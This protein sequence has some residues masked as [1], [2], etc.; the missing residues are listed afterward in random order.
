[1]SRLYGC[2]ISPD[3]VK[4]NRA[5]LVAVADKF[6]HSIE[7]IEDGVLFDL[8]GLERLIGKP[9]KI[10]QKINTELRLA[11]ISGSIAVAENI[12]A[13]TLLARAKHGDGQTMI[14]YVK[15]L[16]FP[17]LPLDELFLEPDTLNVFKDLGLHTIEDLLAVP[18]SDLIDRYGREF[19][20]VIRTIR[21]KGDRLLS[22][23]VK[24]SQVSWSF[25]LDNAVEDFEQLIFLLNHGLEML[26]AG[27]SRYGH[28]TE[29]LDITFQLCRSPRMS[30]GLSSNTK[31][32]EIKSSTPSLDRAFW[33]KLVNVRV[34]LD[35]PEAGIVG[36]DVTAHFTKQ[37]PNQR[38]LYAVSRPEPESLLLTV[39]KIKKLVGKENVGIPRLV[40]QRLAHPFTLD[41]DAIPDVTSDQRLSRLAVRRGSASPDDGPFSLA[42]MPPIRG[43]ASEDVESIWTARRASPQC[44]AAEPQRSI[45][46]FTWFNP[47]IPAEVLMRSG[48]LVFI[49]TREFSGHIVNCSGV[50]RSNS[51]WWD[52]PWKVQEW[53]VEVENGGIY[54]V[55]KREKEWFVT[56]EYD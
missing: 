39:G 14:C 41:A 50:W 34:S 56:G 36:V 26:F 6:S 5:G 28:S 15:G 23:N 9:E 27:V 33:L 10:S 13:A 24:E 35:P 19:E 43:I 21:Q 8:T 46:A 4:Q 45:L 30:K 1:M 42:A 48:E 12:E 25:A 51:K 29:Q 52:K 55:C 47:P 37:R 20:S 44:E 17:Q 32:Y 3:V 38:G 40:D 31:R 53:D 7:V 49:K 22:P 11:G 16:K 54:R 2:V 18:E